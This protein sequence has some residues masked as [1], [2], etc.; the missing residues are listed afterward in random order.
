M[1]GIGVFLALNWAYVYGQNV[2]SNDIVMQAQLSLTLEQY[3]L[4]VMC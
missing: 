1:L 4:Q 3:L 2:R